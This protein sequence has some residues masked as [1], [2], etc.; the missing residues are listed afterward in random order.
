VA[1]ERFD[2][3]TWFVCQVGG[4]LPVCMSSADCGIPGLILYTDFVS[5]AE[6]QVSTMTLVFFL[7][8]RIF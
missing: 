2:R 3:R 4:H 1:K 7:A 8:L 6:E 5:P